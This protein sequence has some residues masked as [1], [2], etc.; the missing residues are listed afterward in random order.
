MPGSTSRNAPHVAPEPP[1]LDEIDQTLVAALREDGRAALG[2]LGVRV[3]LSGDAVRERL[4]R[5]RS[6]GAVSVA[7][8]PDP[9]ALGY[10]TVAL[11]ALRVR[12]AVLPVAQRLAAVAQV[13]FV[14]CTVGSFDLLAEVL[15]Q[16]DAQLVEL[17]DREVRA[18]PEVEHCSV[19][20]YLDVVKWTPGGLGGGVPPSP[21]PTSPAA[22]DDADRAIM[23][24]L[25]LDGRATYQDLAHATGLTYANARRRARALIEMGRVRIVTTVNRLVEGTAVLAAVGLR[26]SGPIDA[27]HAAIAAIEEVEVAVHTTG[28]YDLVLDI[29]CR[30]RPHLVQ[31]LNERLGA[32]PGAHVEQTLVYAR[33]EKLPLQWSAQALGEIVATGG[34]AAGPS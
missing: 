31:V 7:G 33:L 16:D 17:L 32:I 27:V 19:L 12:G 30:D 5:L 34:A 18:L 22:L 28:P 25:Q 21:A 6:A 13:D 14:A 3:G 23:A 4:R 24:A 9:H 29:A 2:A 20:L 15:A 1:V 10:R 11:V 8:T 26:T